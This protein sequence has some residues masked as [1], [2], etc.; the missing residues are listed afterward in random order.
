[1]TDPLPSDGELEILRVLW[2]IGPATVKTVHERLPRRGEIGYNTVGKLLGIMEGK[3]FVARD[4]TS[5]A[6]V[7]R[8]LI[9][10]DQAERGFVRDLADR[11]FGG[12][13]AAL[14]LRAL[15]ETPPTADEIAEL[16]ALL[17]ELEE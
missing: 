4:E 7:F 16:K 13:P 2:R 5:R 10:R 6:H 1:V 8:P 15:G 11:A 9:D 3:G 14:A 12:S 17:A